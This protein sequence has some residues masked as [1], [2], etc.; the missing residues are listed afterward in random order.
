MVRE[1]EEEEGEYGGNSEGI[2]RVFYRNHGVGER[3]LD[4]FVYTN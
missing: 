2:C 1:E 3:N 4:Y